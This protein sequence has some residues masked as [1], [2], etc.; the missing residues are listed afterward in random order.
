MTVALN[1]EK[2]KK[3]PQRITKIKPFINKYNWEGI[4]FP[5]EKNDWKKFEKDNVTVALNVL[6]AKR[7][8]IYS[9][10]VFKNNSNCEKQVILFMISN[11]EKL[12]HYL[13]VKKLSTLLRGITSKHHGDFYCLS[14]L[15]SFSTEK[16][17]NCIKKYVKIKIFVM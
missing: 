15:Y 1:Y 7:E 10:Y 6:Y 8:K 2:T 14:C 16:I 11:G 9:A 3:D 12:W 5:L 17:L 4:N 13:P